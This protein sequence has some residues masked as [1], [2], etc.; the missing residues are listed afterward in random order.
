MCPPPGPSMSLRW[1]LG[2]EPYYPKMCLSPLWQLQVWG[3]GFCRKLGDIEAGG[4]PGL[5]YQGLPE[6]EKE[7]KAMEYRKCGTEA[8]EV[9]RCGPPSSK[10]RGLRRE[11]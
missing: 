5:E 4:T 3:S 1:W 6:G 10:S 8:P 2:E 9:W 7:G 11:G